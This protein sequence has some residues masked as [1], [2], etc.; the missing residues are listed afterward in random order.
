MET[1][2]KSRLPEKNKE[3]LMAD[4]ERLKAEMGAQFDSIKG[5]AMDIGR[6]VLLIGAAIYLGVKLIKYLAR[7]KKRKYRRY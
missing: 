3:M 1:L 5:D 4:Q 2:D 7:D 6:Q